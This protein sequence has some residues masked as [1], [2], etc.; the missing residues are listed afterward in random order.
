MND[1]IKCLTLDEL[2]DVT[3]VRY[4]LDGSLIFPS[5]SVSQTPRATAWKRQ[6]GAQEQAPST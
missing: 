4:F 5:A 3:V 1:E 6:A 2:D